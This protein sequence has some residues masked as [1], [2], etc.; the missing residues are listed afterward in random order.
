MNHWSGVDVVGSAC[1][2]LGHSAVPIDKLLC[3]ESPI[4]SRLLVSP[5]AGTTTG[6]VK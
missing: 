3:D 1:L 5:L 2:V 6:R 4:L